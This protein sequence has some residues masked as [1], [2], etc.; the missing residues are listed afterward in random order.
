MI[1][2]ALG[3]A[4]SKMSIIAGIGKDAEK[5]ETS[6]TNDRIESS[7]K[8]VEYNLGFSQMSIHRVNI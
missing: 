2:H 7:A 8:S 6:H 5:L 1:S 4:Q 3:W